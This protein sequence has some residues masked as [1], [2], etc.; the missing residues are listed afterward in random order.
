V[1]YV[2]DAHNQPFI[3]PSTRARVEALRQQIIAGTIKP[4]SVPK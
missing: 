3:A 2:Y 1:D 4:P